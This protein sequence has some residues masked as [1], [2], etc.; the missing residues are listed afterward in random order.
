[1]A[2]PSSCPGRARGRGRARPM[3]QSSARGRP[4]GAHPRGRPRHRARVAVDHQEAAPA[5][6]R[7][8]WARGASR[9]WAGQRRAPRRAVPGTP[10]RCGIGAGARSY[11]SGRARRGA[12]M[13]RACRSARLSARV[14]ARPGGR[15]ARSGW[16]RGAVGVGPR[17]GRGGPAASSRAWAR[18][19]R[20]G[21][22]M[23][24]ART[25]RAITW[26]ARGEA[27]SARTRRAEV[28]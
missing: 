18:T 15:A 3:A 26:R 9:K 6:A 14:E 20:R 7:E 10:A 19:V 21:K 25:G 16:A 12:A 22:E 28:T 24:R 1:M 23:A 27:G 5:M 17:R 4:V 13:A 8:D 11:R 2:R